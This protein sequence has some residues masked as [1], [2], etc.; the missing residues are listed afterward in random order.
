MIAFVPLSMIDPAE[1]QALWADP[2]VVTHMP[3]ADPEPWTVDDVREWVAGK[4]AFKV[5]TELFYVNVQVL[6][7]N[8]RP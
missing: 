7:A 3:L 4:D 1:F 8:G 5:A 6:Q 2:R